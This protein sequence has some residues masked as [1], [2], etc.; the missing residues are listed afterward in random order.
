MKYKR[1]RLLRQK[2]VWRIRKR[3]SG[4]ALRPRVCLHFSNRHIYVQAIDDEAGR[5]LVSLSSL[6]KDLRTRN[7]K[8]DVEGAAEIGLLFSEKAK[9]AGIKRIVFDRNGRLYHGAVKA[10]AEASRKVGLEF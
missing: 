8:A 9:E 6:N 4:N 10:F 2:R 1:K 3:I 7:L 5:T